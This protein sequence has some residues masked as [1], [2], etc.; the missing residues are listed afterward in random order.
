MLSSANLEWIEAKKVNDHRDPFY[1]YRSFKL[2]TYSTLETIST[3]YFLLLPKFFG[4]VLC[5]E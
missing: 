4:F 2:M 5:L 1:T 3:D